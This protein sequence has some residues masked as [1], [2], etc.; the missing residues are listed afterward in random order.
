MYYQVGGTN[1]RVLGAMHVFPVQNTNLPSWVW[2]GFDWCDDLFFEHCDPKS[3]ADIPIVTRLRG[4]TT[5]QQLMSPKLWRT[6]K[7]TIPEWKKWNALKPWIVFASI[8]AVMYP[9]F[10]GVEKQFRNRLTTTPKPLAFLETPRTSAQA[11]ETVPYRD[12]LDMLE[13][14][15]ENPVALKQSF[16]DYYDAWIGCRM[17]DFRSCAL[18]DPMAIFPAYRQG[19]IVARNRNWMDNIRLA[20]P[21]S[22]KILFVVGGGHLF[23]DGGLEPLFAKE[24][25]PLIP[26]FRS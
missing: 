22:R 21:S 1:L 23:G 4:G 24:N 16:L 17:D 15:L 10:N 8:E 13:F 12:Y 6:F 19:M 5:L 18:R 25:H 2:D 9:H 14:M 7:A 3:D 11:F 26:L 20:F